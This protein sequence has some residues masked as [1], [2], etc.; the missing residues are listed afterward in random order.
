MGVSRVTGAGEDRPKAKHLWEMEEQPQRLGR[1]QEPGWSCP[2]GV[3]ECSL[4]LRGGPGPT[5]PEAPK[6]SAGAAEG[7]SC[8][9]VRPQP[10]RVDSEELL[11]T[12]AGRDHSL[13]GTLALPPHLG[14][15]AE[16]VGELLASGERQT[17]R[18]SFQRDWRLE[19]MVQDR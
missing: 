16:V 6:P 9:G 10:R 4:P 18:E 13:A 7:V 19:A 3:G 17:W 15:A 8:Q 5:V 2:R 11:W 14:T 1:N 12:W